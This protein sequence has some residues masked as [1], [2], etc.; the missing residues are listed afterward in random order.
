MPPNNTGAVGLVYYEFL[1]LNA[2]LPSV[3]TPYQ[4][5]ASGFDNEKFNGDYGTSIGS[6]TSE[7]PSAEISKTGPA[8]RKPGEDAEYTITAENTGDVP[9]G[10]PDFGV[11]VV[12][13]DPIPAGL[14]YVAGTADTSANVTDPDG[15]QFTVEY[16][17]DDG[18]TWTATEPVPASDVNRIRW[19]LDR[20]LGPGDTATVNFSAFVPLGYTPLSFTNTAILKTGYD[21]EVDRSSWTTRLTGDHQIGDLVWLDLNGDGIQ[22]SGELGIQNVTVRLYH[23]ADNNGILDPTDPLYAHCAK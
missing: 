18:A 9:Y 23:D 1:P 14:Q 12:I 19:V 6:A 3:L 2:S 7:S 4:E 13:E 11:P 15:G 21:T 8:T 20:P 16:S 22:D 10:W 5:V 17:T